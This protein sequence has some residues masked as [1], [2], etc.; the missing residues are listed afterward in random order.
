MSFL[1]KKYD[2]FYIK[3]ISPRLRL[4]STNSRSNIIIVNREYLNE[5]S[6]TT[7]ELSDI[8]T[9][10][11]LL[12]IRRTLTMCALRT[13][14]MDFFYFLDA[15]SGTGKTFLKNVRKDRKIA[16]AVASSGIAATLLDEKNSFQS[17]TAHSVFKLTLNKHL[18]DSALQHFKAN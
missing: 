18:P 7:V 9:F 4:T 14:M 12:R 13:L 2:L 15:P 11:N 6:L 8:R 3:P 1:Y 16:S 17:K 10:L 5:P